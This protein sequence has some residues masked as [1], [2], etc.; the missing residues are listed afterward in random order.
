MK[1]VGRTL[2]IG[3]VRFSVERDDD[4]NECGDVEVVSQRIRINDSHGH[5]IQTITIF[6]ES[7]HAILELN[8]YHAESNNEHMVDCLANGIV[9]LLRD[10]KWVLDR[11]K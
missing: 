7:I 9:S 4:A 6:H 5:D 10:N 11:L 8:Q 1:V 3:P 2:R